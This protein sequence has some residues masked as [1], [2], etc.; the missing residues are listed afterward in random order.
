M[1]RPDFG[2]PVTCESCWKNATCPR[3][4]VDGFCPEWQTEE[5]EPKGTDPRDA[6]NQGEEN[7]YE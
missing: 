1:A 3:A 6:W 5:P 4:M 7:P 2:K